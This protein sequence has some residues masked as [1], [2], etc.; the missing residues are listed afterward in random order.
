M[1]CDG[2]VGCAHTTA[3]I[4]VARRVENVVVLIV[5]SAKPDLEVLKINRRPVTAGATLHQ[6]KGGPSRVC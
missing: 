3:V 4:R 6:I 2:G 1:P 5:A